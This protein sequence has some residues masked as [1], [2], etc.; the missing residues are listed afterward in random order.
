MNLFGRTVWCELVP[1]G[2]VWRLGANNATT[3]EL[4]H[5]ARI[6][7]NDIAPGKYALFAIPAAD[8][9]TLILNRKHAQWGAYF[10]DAKEDA[11]RFTVKSDKADFREWFDISMTP[12][13]EKALR[14]EILWDKVRVPFLIEFDTPSDWETFHQAAR[15]AL[16]TG[17]RL[18]DAMQWIEKAMVKESFWN[19]ELKALLL[20]KKG[21]TDEAY[22]L[23]EKAK[24]LA[25]G[26]APAEYVEGLDRTVAGW[27]ASSSR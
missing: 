2:K 24:E 14:V 20:H 7:G 4:S 16:I 27:R 17:D 10:H 23:M 15:Y 11:L 3:L 13:T 26:K 21:R 12:A 19:Y 8:Q 6:N 1:Y 18:D 5:R 9:W 22:P 25:R